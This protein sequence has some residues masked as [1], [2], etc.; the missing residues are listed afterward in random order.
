VVSQ[1]SIK[2][3]R[4]S[5]SKQESYKRVFGWTLLVFFLALLVH[6][7]VWYQYQENPFFE[8]LIADSYFYHQK[9]LRIMEQGFALESVFY[10]APLYPT[11]LS[12]IYSF[13]SNETAMKN[14]VI[15]V[16]IL[17]TSLAIAILVPLG[18]K[19]LR[20]TV[21]GVIGAILILLHGSTVFYSFKYFPQSL[22]LATTA[23]AWFFLA[24]A[25][26]RSSYVMTFILGLTMGVACLA[27]PEIILGWPIAVLALLLVNG[28]FKKRITFACVFLFAFALTLT[29]AAIHNSRQGDKVLIA[30]S[31]GENLYIAN[32][33][34]EGGGLSVLLEQAI[35]MSKQQEIT[36]AVAEQE[37]GRELRPSE[38]SAYWRNR[39]F[40]EILS[41]PVRWIRLEVKKLARIFHPGDPA[42][43]YSLPLERSQYLAFLYALPLSA[44]TLLGLGLIGLILALRFRAR[45]SWPLIALV[46]IRL[47]VLLAF[48]VQTRLRLPLLFFLAPFGGYAIVKG[49]Q[50]WKENRHRL[51]IGSLAGLLI[52]L[53][54]TGIILTRQ[55]PRDVVRLAAVLSMQGRS[56]EALKAL[57]PVLDDPTPYGMA[58]D[59]AGWLNQKKGNFREARDLYEKA[60]QAGLTKERMT[61]SLTRLA[62]VLEELGDMK[63]AGEKH[64]LAAASS[65]ANA[66][67]YYERAIFHLKTGNVEGGMQDLRKAI[68]LD[69]KWAQPQTML[70]EVE[71]QLLINKQKR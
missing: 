55:T 69:P 22:S 9:A 8:T 24:M 57:Q 25:R 47:A 66:G 48:T 18:Y 65:Y 50:N 17:L 64:D 37:T 63:E 27:R 16:Q 29:P 67:T 4:T 3:K 15:A 19:Y 21:A 14:A 40:R 34:D 59:Q 35:D 26:D 60:H 38:L 23:L 54:I 7:P 6:L 12:W 30:Y 10:Q 1:T 46:G 32:Q 62:V 31:G 58:Y 68:E 52:I 2:A 51:L 43:V 42:D 45:D 20:S 70:E 61:H 39:A 33:P 36:K 49:W 71:K 28:D 53:S 11:M 5:P 44:W 41:D 13:V 56:E